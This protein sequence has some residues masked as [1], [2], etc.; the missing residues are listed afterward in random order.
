[1]KI[2][3]VSPKL[4]YP[5]RDG[6]SLATLQLSR[7][8]SKLGHEVT[9]LSINTKKHYFPLDDIP[10][11]LKQKIR[12]SATTVDT[13]LKPFKLARN[14][15]L[16]REPY[17]LERFYDKGFAKLI[18]DTLSNENFDIIQFEGPYFYKYLPLFR[19]YSKAKFA[20]RA[21][22]VENHIWK[23][24]A[25]EQSNFMAR[26]Y[27][28]LTASRLEKFEKK[29]LSAYDM[30]ITITAKDDTY[31][32]KQPGCP[33]SMVAPFGIDT[34]M[35]IPKPDNT[36]PN[37]ICFIG[38]LDWKPNQSSLIW[39]VENVWK[40]LISENSQIY[41]HVAGRNAP[42]WIKDQLKINQII[43]HGEVENAMDFISESE[44]LVVPLFSGSGIRVKIIEAMAM[45]KAIITTSA[46][47]SGI[48]CENGKHLIIANS[49]NEFQNQIITLVGH[50]TK[51]LEISSEAK[52]LVEEQYENMEI[53]RAIINFYKMYK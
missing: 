39:F 32:K 47:C 24:L 52:K 51:L 38:A 46:G 5:S 9:V 31:F 16:S 13:S 29:M 15:I 45:E 34:E 6:G 53:C 10:D 30:L 36:K 28:K 20:L 7:G 18:S 21:H 12:F 44:V 3:Q 41:F 37:T 23:K 35:Y 27:L 50:K 14:L 2:L 49:A 40:P 42:Q 33:P 26:K 25:A 4:P 8:Y 1:M 43:F 11:E 22:N 48:A 17:H 19:K